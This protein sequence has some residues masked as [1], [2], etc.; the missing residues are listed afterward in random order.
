[1]AVLLRQKGQ[2]SIEFILILVFAL[3]YIHLY[4]WPT[5]EDSTQTASDVKA[6]ADAKVSAMKLAS[7]VDEAGTTHG[8]M[9]KTIKIFLPSDAQMTCR[10][11]GEN[12]GIEFSA[13]ISAAGGTFNPDEEH[14]IEV[15]D[16]ADLVGFECTAVVPVLDAS[17]GALAPCPVMIGP[18]FRDLVVEKDASGT[19][20]ASWG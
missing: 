5:V 1:M 3:V 15:L 10:T 19:I 9:K 18:L 6:I 8:E 2:I 20:T 17:A 7:A 4:V 13:V 16:G 12:K 11:S 14:C